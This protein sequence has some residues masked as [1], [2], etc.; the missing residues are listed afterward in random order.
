MNNENNEINEQIAYMRAFTK[1]FWERHPRAVSKKEYN[2]Y[3]N[4]MLTIA[5]YSTVRE[6]AEEFGYDG[7]TFVYSFLPDVDN[8]SLNEAVNEKLNNSLKV[9][10]F[11]NG[12]TDKAF[13]HEQILAL[14]RKKSR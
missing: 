7:D 14:V 4:Y 2:L 8:K 12:E 10:Q 11:K 9:K 5:R 13:K 6:V 3:C 1:G